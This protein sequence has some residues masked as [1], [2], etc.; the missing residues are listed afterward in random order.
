MNDRLFLIEG[1]DNDSDG[2]FS[3]RVVGESFAL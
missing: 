2:I 3:E 1:R